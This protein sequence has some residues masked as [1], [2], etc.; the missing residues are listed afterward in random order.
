MPF[1]PSSWRRDAL[2]AL[3]VCYAV[4]HVHADVLTVAE[5][6]DKSAGLEVEG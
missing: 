4:G 1:T 5:S 6:G 3:A 2:D